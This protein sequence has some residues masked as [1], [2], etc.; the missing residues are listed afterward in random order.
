M[1]GEIEVETSVSRA[2][3]RKKARFLRGPIPLDALAKAACLPGKAL[4]VFLAVH[5]RCNLESETSVTL[6]AALLASFGVD[7]NAKA[8]AL[9]NLEKAG[10]VSV[11]RKVDGAARVSLVHDLAKQSK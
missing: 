2:R 4:A 10:L 3:I 6:P 7:R 5:H 8:C 9:R 1:I 11:N